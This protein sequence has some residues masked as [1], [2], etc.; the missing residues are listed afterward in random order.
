M[1]QKVFISYRR[2]DSK[3]QARQI[4]NALQQ[5]L[6]RG[7]VFMDIDAIP[8]GADFVELLQGFVKQCDILLALIGPGWTNVTDPKT[9][10]RRLQNER[11]LVRVEVREA[12]TRNIRVVP[13]LLDGTPMPDVNQ[14]PDDLKKLAHRQAEIVE[15]RT[16]EHDVQRLITKLDLDLPDYDAFISYRGQ[17]AGKLARWIRERLLHYKL[18]ENVLDLLTDTKRQIHK[19]KPRIC[20]DSNHENATDDFLTRLVFPALDSSAWLIVILT[21]SVLGMIPGRTGTQEPNRLVREVDR[22]LGD[23]T[24]GVSSR[25]IDVVLGPEWR[26]EDPFPGRLGETDK[27]EWI[28]L[29]GFSWRQSWGLSRS[30]DDGLALLVGRLYDVPDSARPLLRDLLR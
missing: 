2:D 5:V 18:P 1:S 6:P 14:L 8:P 23:A 25:P 16:F 15:Y 7:N 13:V 3:Y 17:D 4:C 12:L 9:N 28:D 27:W 30:L 20:L 10:Q 24:V 19:R 29:R 26:D 22:F 21:P 11:D